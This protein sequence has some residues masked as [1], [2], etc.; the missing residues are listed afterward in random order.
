VLSEN[1]KD[2]TGEPTCAKE[3]MN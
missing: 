2:E 1:S 3:V